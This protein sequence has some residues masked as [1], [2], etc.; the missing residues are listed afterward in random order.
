MLQTTD[1]LH[2]ETAAAQSDLARVLVSLELSRSTW[3]VTVLAPDSEKMSK[4]QVEGGDADALLALLDRLKA[5]TE[6]RLGRQVQIVTIQEAGLDGFWLHRRLKSHGTLSHI[7]EPASI[8][9]PRRHRRAKTD[10]IDGEVLIRTLAAWLRGEPRVCSMVRPPSPEEEDRR[11][12][13]REREQLIAERIRLVNRIKG[14]LFGQ[15]IRDYQP[16]H[17]DRWQ[18]LEALATGDGQPLPPQLKAELSRMLERLDLVCRQLEAVEQERDSMAAAVEPVAALM[19]LKGIGPEIAARLWLEA[20]YRTFSNRRQVAAYAGLTPTPWQSGDSSREQGVS[21]SGNPRPRTT[22]IE[23][24]WLW[25]R[26]Q[27][28]SALSQ[29]FRERVGD[30]RGRVR[31]VAIVAVARKLL[32]ALWRY[33]TQG[34]LPEGADLKTA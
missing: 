13:T 30:R 12:L 21:K 29:G 33:V 32:I 5:R 7:V 24:A 14:L 22:I 2:R 17:R 27:P 23:L 6:Q 28:G 26:H 11:R 31:M 16:L 8:A 9:V 19:Q 25:L 1:Y 18:R 20:L 4:H 10:R 34:V 3:L 15:G